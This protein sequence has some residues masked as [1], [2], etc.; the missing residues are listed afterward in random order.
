VT[1][2]G[3]EILLRLVVAAALGAAVGLDRE[4][5]DRAAGTRTHLLVSLGAALFTL[6][7][8]Y[9]FAGGPRADPSRV[10]AQIVT[11]I[12]FLGAGVILR[13]GF[14]V[15][16]LTTAG[17]LW[18]VAAIGMAAGAGAYWAA[19]ATAIITLIALGPLKKAL[20]AA[21][22]ANGAQRIVVELGEVD[23]ATPVIDL[24]KD[25]LSIQISDTDRGR[26]VSAEVEHSIDTELLRRIADNEHVKAVRVETGTV[27]GD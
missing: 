9:G 15:R 25:P 22:P 10:A 2:G 23:D 17:S 18:V 21:I 14:S 13:Q 27:R 26:V 11:G 8:A 7:G 3:W 5:R 12:G 6:V 19:V 1:I 20:S 24:I 16:G 4:L